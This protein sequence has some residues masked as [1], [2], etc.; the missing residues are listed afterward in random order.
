MPSVPESKHED[1]NT[2]SKNDSSS[3]GDDDLLTTPQST[4]CLFHQVDE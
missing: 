4:Q 1:S 2:E 3:G